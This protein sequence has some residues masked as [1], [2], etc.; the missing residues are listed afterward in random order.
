MSVGGSA[1]GCPPDVAPVGQATSGPW[2]LPA[3]ERL[4]YNSRTPCWVLGWRPGRVQRC[5]TPRPARLSCRLLSSLQ[6]CTAVPTG[7]GVPTT[8]RAGL[9]V[10]PV[11][12]QLVTTPHRCQRPI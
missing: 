9:N 10:L 5:L 2:L 12:P 1:T 3:H 4:V 6:S 8:P 11:A 7:S